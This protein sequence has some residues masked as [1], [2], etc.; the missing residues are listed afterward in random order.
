MRK[1]RLKDLSGKVFGR[2]TVIKFIGV[3]ERVARWECLC[4]CGI[5]KSYRS[6]SLISGH[7][8]SCGC[9]GMERRSGASKTHG[10]R[11][12]T[13]YQSWCNMRRRCYDEQNQ[14]YH[15]YGGRGIIVC[16]RWLGKNGFS[17]FYKDM[18]ERPTKNH[19][20]ERRNND[21]NYEP[22]NC[23][24]DT[25]KVQANNRSTN[26]FIEHNGVIK[27]I[28]EWEMIIL[29]KSKGEIT[30]RMKRGQ[31]FEQVYN[32]FTNKGNLV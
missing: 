29:G 18:G 20:L 32:Y 28:T 1:T 7:T 11:N 5:V 4:Q 3:Q 14:K 21:G 19:T 12:T 9:L 30:R 17:N 25:K 2:L 22:T 27:T 8:A 23:G 16:E 26:H 13:E 15:R 6:A 10:K 24:W 31:T